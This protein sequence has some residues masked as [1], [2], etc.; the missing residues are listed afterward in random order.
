ML[1]LIAVALALRHTSCYIALLIAVGA[2]VCMSAGSRNFRVLIVIIVFSCIAWLRGAA[3]YSAPSGLEAYGGNTVTVTAQMLTYPEYGSGVSAVFK[4]L[5]VDGEAVESAR[6]LVRVYDCNL[7]FAPGGVYQF[8]GTL[9]I[10]GNAS[11]PGGFDYRVYLASQN[12]KCYMNIYGSASFLHMAHLPFYYDKILALRAGCDAVLRANLDTDE[13]GLMSGML[14]GSSFMDGALLADYRA[15]GAAHILAVSGLHVGILYA[16]VAFILKRLKATPRVSF[17]VVTSTLALYVML[18]GFSVS[19]I[20]AALMFW[21]MS[22]AGALK[23]KTDPFNCLCVAACVLLACNP[24]IFYSVSFQMS[25]CAAAALIIFLPPVRAKVRMPKNKFWAGFAGLLL[26]CLTVQAGLLPVTAY[27][28]HNVNALS[29]AA[30]LLIIPAVSAALIFGLAAVMLSACMPAAAPAFFGPISLFLKAL[31]GFVSALANLKFTVFYIASPRFCEIAL[32]Y[33]VMFLL[34]GYFILKS[35]KSRILTGAGFIALCACCIMLYLPPLHTV[36]SFLDVGFGDCCI[37]RTNKGETIIID[38]GGYL[39]ADTAQYDIV[40]F[41]DITKSKPSTPSS[42][43]T[44][45]ATT[46]T[47]SSAFLTTAAS[48]STRFTQTTTGRCFTMRW[49]KKQPR[50]ILR[51]NRCMRATCLNTAA[52]FST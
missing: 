20:R 16:L 34:C 43:R 51:S 23:R 24:F 6:I 22:L 37:I 29:L 28:F 38:G 39:N 18:T 52:P 40:P 14:F 1:V 36:V 19:V 13:A 48:G 3:V 2:A 46:S 17:A 35:K 9:N 10:A 15:V 11:N 49:K 26:A 30:N 44:A 31:N 33:M 4:C 50:A 12:I 32:C 5:S 45:T 21:L 47:A 27:Y 7:S 25:F 41:L 8:T 42:S